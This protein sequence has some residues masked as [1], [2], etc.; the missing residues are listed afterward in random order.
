VAVVRRYGT[1]TTTS[2]DAAPTPVALAARIG[3]TGTK[4]AATGDVLPV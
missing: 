1:V 2:F 4:A 3:V